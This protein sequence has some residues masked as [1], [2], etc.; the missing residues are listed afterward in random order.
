MVAEHDLERG[1]ESAV[2]QVPRAVPVREPELQCGIV[3][4]GSVY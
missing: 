1:V 4:S 3:E 2:S